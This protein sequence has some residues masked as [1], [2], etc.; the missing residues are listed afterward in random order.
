MS[1]DFDFRLRF[2]RRYSMGHRL[3][4]VDIV[5]GANHGLDPD[6]NMLAEFDR[7]KRRWFQWIDSSV[8]HSFHI[9]NQDPLLEYFQKN[10]PELLPK[11]LVTPGDP[12]TEIR[13]ACFKSKLTVF[14]AEDEPNFRCDCLIIQ[15]TPANAVEIRADNFRGIL[16]EG[17]HWWRRADSSINSMG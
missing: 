15:E 17:D 9:G 7:V 13:A 3:V 8:D 1:D 5:H 11:L 4:T 14:L 12:T 6:T 16:P 10:E 2:S